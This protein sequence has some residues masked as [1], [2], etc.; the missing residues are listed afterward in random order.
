MLDNYLTVNEVAEMWNLDSRRVQI[1]CA[2]GE[3]EG[4]VKFGR[5]WAIPSSAE[6]PKDKRITTGKW[7]DY[8][9]NKQSRE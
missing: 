9:K 8:R 2:N 3:I 5:A 7:I 1:L 6:K 4:A